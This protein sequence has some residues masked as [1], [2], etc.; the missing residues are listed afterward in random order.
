MSALLQRILIALGKRGVQSPIDQ[1]LA[2][3]Y[4]SLQRYHEAYPSVF[5]PAAEIL[6][7]EVE[8]GAT[9]VADIPTRLGHLIQML[10]RLHR[11]E[12]LAAWSE[13]QEVVVVS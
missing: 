5:N 13:E 1:D 9:N 11:E 4:R 12:E 3:A 2:A 6:L 10:D 7:A 8:G